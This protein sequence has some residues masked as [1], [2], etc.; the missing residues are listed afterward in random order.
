MATNRRSRQ[1][2][3]HVLEQTRGDAVQAL[4]RRALLF[5]RIAKAASSRVGRSSA[6]RAKSA[7]LSQLLHLGAADV[8]MVTISISGGPCLHCPVDALEPAAREAVI[9]RMVTLCA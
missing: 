5:N 2:F 3:A 1:S 9:Q 7:A 8:E 4:S 6:Y